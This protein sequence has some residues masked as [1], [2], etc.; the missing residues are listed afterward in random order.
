MI[1]EYIQLAG[2]KFEVNKTA[3]DKAGSRPGSQRN[4]LFLDYHNQS[5]KMRASKEEVKALRNQLAVSNPKLLADLDRAEKY[6][7]KQAK[8]RAP[9]KNDSKVHKVM[10]LAGLSSSKTTNQLAKVSSQIMKQG[11]SFGGLT[12]HKGKLRSR[13]AAWLAAVGDPFKNPPAKCPVNYNPMPTLQTQVFRTTASGKVQVQSG[14]NIQWTL[15]P[16]HTLAV[17][18]DEMDGPSYHMNWQCSNPSGV[19]NFHPVGPVNVLDGVVTTATNCIISSV[20][21]TG[22]KNGGSIG[23]N[24][25]VTDTSYYN[26][27]SPAQSST[28]VAFDTTLPLTANAKD[29]G[30]TR[31]KLTAMEIRFRNETPEVDRGGEFYSVQPLNTV[32][33]DAIKAYSLFATF[34][35]HGICD[36][37]E[38]SVKWIPRVQDLAFWHCGPKTNYTNG[39]SNAGILLWFVNTTGKTQNLSW[40][41]LCHWEMGGSNIQTMATPSIQQPAD[42]NIVAPTL[43]VLQSSTHTATTA[44]RVAEVISST[45]SPGYLGKAVD[46]IGRDNV[47]GAVKALASHIGGPGA[48]AIARVMIPHV[49]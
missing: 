27:A 46:F 37:K 21:N 18:A 35:N 34:R 48:E 28:A 22:G 9:R 36:V 32:Q 12:A 25:V 16:G 2:L 30:H 17:D 24:S 13:L 6:Y 3:G 19:V 41:L 44:P 42:A 33:F 45:S 4:Y 15:F 47:E 8:E 38:G 39:I 11:Y 20:D 43:S 10:D 5:S 7:A 29:G 40:E 31:W 1:G 26:A 23:V 49:F 14:R